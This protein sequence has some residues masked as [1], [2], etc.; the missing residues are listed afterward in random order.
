M[1]RFTVICVLLGSLVLAGCQK[2]DFTPQEQAEQHYRNGDYDAMLTACEEAIRLDPTNPELFVLRGN[3]FFS[4]ER[5]ELAVVAFT[6]AL[7]L[8]PDHFPAYYR[9]SEAYKQLGKEDEAFADGLIAREKDPSYEKARLNETNLASEPIAAPPTQPLEAAA[10]DVAAEEPITRRRLWERSFEGDDAFDALTNGGEPTSAGPGSR[11]SL[12]RPTILPN[13]GGPAPGAGR[14]PNGPAAG[15]VAADTP[16]AEIPSPLL[17]PS[18]GASED[19]EAMP[20]DTAKQESPKP[21][22]RN[23]MRPVWPGMDRAAGSQGQMPQVVIPPRPPSTGIQ[24]GRTAPAAS[25]GNPSGVYSPPSTGISSQP[26]RSTYSPAGAQPYS[27]YGGPSR[28]TTGIS[29]VPRTRYPSGPTPPGIAPTTPSR[30]TT[31]II[32]Q[33]R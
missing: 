7:E 8:D 11:P 32:S 3:A 27:P 21:R 5:Y 28:P 20:E 13:G 12:S 30:P 6:K 2:P 10:D 19:G 15:G 33:P 22:P 29:S 31:G 23:L 25:A 1:C 4:Q 16:G 26:R 14:L 24:S 9:R 18:D 17:P